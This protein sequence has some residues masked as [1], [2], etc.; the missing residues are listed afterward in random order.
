MCF[1]YL[2]FCFFICFVFFLEHVNQAPYITVVY[3]FSFYYFLF[4]QQI[5]GWGAINIIFSAPV[6]HMVVIPGIGPFIQFILCYKVCNC[7]FTSLCSYGKNLNALIFKHST[8]QGV[9]LRQLLLAM[10]ATRG[11]EYQQCILC[12]KTLQA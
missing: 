9:K 1:L 3:S 6:A 4:V 11:V 12:F 8:V 2:G 5:Y 7:F 10:P